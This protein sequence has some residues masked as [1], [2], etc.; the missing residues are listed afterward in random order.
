MPAMRRKGH[1][2]K[3]FNF[4]HAALAILLL[5]AACSPIRGNWTA[6]DLETATH[7]Y[8]SQ[9]A[10]KEYLRI[11]RSS[12]DF[13]RK[14]T[15]EESVALGREMRKARSEALQVLA[16]PGFLKKVHQDIREH[17]RDEYLRSLELTLQNMEHPNYDIAELADRL[18]NSYVEWYVDH[19]TE[20]HLPKER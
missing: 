11:I 14:F 6:Q 12:G 2:M 7:F 4:H 16:D 3:P 5:L 19:Q 1:A 13:N 20:I 15:Y 9:R 18:Y 17:Y 10:N 8:K